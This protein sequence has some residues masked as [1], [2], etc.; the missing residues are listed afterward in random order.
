MNGTGTGKLKV[1]AWRLCEDCD[2]TGFLRDGT[3]RPPTCSCDEGKYRARSRIRAAHTYAE[4]PATYRAA[5]FDNF[6]L[7][8]REVDPNG[9]LANA[10]RVSMAFADGTLGSTFLILSGQFGVGKTHL[11]AAIINYCIAN[12]G[13]G[14]GKFAKVPEMLQ[15]FRNGFRDNTYQ[16]LFDQI[17][18]APL[19]VLDDLGAEYQ[20]VGDMTTWVAEQL[21]LIVDHRYSEGL[22]TVVTTNVRQDRIEG[23]ILDRLMHTAGG[24]STIVL[25]EGRSYRTRRK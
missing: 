15:A 23:R 16:A 3:D 10:H 7:P 12:T 24:F 25:M 8:G 20:K 21:Y 2:G 11:G 6:E 18:E 14:P 9:S 1:A 17:R 13:L 5:T 22:P 19:L 4:L